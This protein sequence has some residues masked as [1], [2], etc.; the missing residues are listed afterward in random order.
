MAK[1]R[2]L[3]GG[4]S[5]RSPPR[6]ASVL[7]S[8]TK[9][10]LATALVAT[11][12][13]VCARAHAQG[14]EG[15]PITSSSYSV[16]FTQGPVLS[17]SRVTGLAGAATALA[18]GI[19][20]GLSNPASV[21]ARSAGSADSW[22]YWLAFG[23]T[24]PFD[25]GDFYNSG[26]YLQD[27]GQPKSDN[28]LFLNTGA[29]LQLFK[30]GMGLNLEILQ[31]TAQAQADDQTDNKLYL[32]LVTSHVQ[33]GYL[34]FDGQV[35]LGLGLQI[36]QVSQERTIDGADRQRDQRLR[37]A[38]GFGGEV[39][40]LLRPN[41]KQ[42]RIGAGLYS[43]IQTAYADQEMSSTSNALILPKYAVRPW[44]G[45]VGFAY[46]FGKRPL[47]PRW[48]YVEEHAREKLSELDQRVTQADREHAHRLAAIRAQG[49]RDVEQQT[50]AEAR[51]YEAQLELLEAER[52]T[53]RTTAWRELRAGVRKS[54]PRSYL[55]ITSELSFAGRVEQGVGVESFLVQTVQRS[56]ERISVTPRLAAESEV[57]PQHVK[58]RT[59]AYV[60][61][62]RFRE[63][64]PRLHGTLGFD[65]RLFP[66]DVFGIW[67]E[68]YLWQLSAALD[69]SRD[70][71]AFSVGIGG[72]Y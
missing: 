43:R 16:D 5:S 12:W 19:E 58:V 18:E 4:S 23:L 14:E 41:G 31:M 50:A 51:S 20:G 62:A 25:N 13:A 63:S 34:F 49:G 59:G 71:N 47:N 36:L 40:V 10:C 48:T 11:L 53:V 24:Y 6:I 7:R 69:V 27:K 72:W 37:N 38:P 67:P 65:V 35:V 32:R 46:Q 70:Y 8:M 61:P 9:R 42:W 45:N 29:Y 22:D 56:G 39:G 30:A 3:E 33:L 64:D 44:R 57:W 60:E 68:D 26:S 28:V 21:A 66:W 17:T 2:K 55:L 52:D 1:S 15:T 54:W